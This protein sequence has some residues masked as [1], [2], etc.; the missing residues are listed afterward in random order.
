MFNS[1][2]FQIF[3]VALVPLLTIAISSIVLELHSLNSVA[4]QISDITRDSVLEI[5]KRRLETV[6]NSVDSLLGPYL[7]KGAMVGRE[8]ALQML[9]GYQFDKGVGYIFAYDS[10]GTRLL[11]G[12]SDSGIGKNFWDL[13]DKQGQKLI[14]GLIK[15][16]KD[17][18]HYYN[19]WF[20]KPNESEPSPK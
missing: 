20:P 15:A 6:M 2:R 13:Q 18:S 10:T 17:G 14:Q 4:D 12:K 8:S 9:K 11:L 5:E 19:Y 7:A 16:A 3:A 1:L